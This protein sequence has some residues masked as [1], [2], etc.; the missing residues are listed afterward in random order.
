[1]RIANL[2]WTITARCPQPPAAEPAQAIG[3]YVCCKPDG[4]PAA[5][6]GCVASVRMKVLAAR[7]GAAMAPFSKHL[8]VRRFTPGNEG[9]GLPTFANTG[10]SEWVPLSRLGCKTCSPRAA[11]IPQ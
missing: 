1:M 3:L 5:D 2:S 7:A 8:N 6:R 10:V 4:Q 9:C 11:G